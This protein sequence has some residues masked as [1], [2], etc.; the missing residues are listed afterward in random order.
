ME[1]V[2]RRCSA[3]REAGSD[4]PDAYISW[5]LG[6]VL[7]LTSQPLSG[8]ALAKVSGVNYFFGSQNR[9]ARWPGNRCPLSG[10]DST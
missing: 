3:P 2:A 7:L 10:G 4:P 8:G 6:N 5:S 1:A 9:P